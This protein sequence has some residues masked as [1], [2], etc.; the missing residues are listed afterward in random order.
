MFNRY[1]AS[2]IANY[3]VPRRESVY[4][5]L[6]FFLGGLPVVCI[7]TPISSLVIRFQSKCLELYLR[8]RQVIGC[9]L[10]ITICNIYHS[11]T[12]NMSYLFIF[13]RG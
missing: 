12:A 9:V 13:V 7:F 5:L 3:L 1:L 11:Y 4:L 8:G 6:R 10:V 2:R